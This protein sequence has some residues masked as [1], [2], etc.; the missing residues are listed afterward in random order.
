M[1]TPK[2]HAFLERTEPNAFPACNNPA[3][4]A[5]DRLLGANAVFGGDGVSNF[6]W[7]LKEAIVDTAVPSSPLFVADDE[8]WRATIERVV[9]APS[10]HVFLNEIEVRRDL[11]HTPAARAWLTSADAPATA[12]S[13]EPWL[14]N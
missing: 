10:L 2:F 1:K 5:A 6:E 14:E 8:K 7:F 3:L 9:L 12:F 4:C 13:A 11:A